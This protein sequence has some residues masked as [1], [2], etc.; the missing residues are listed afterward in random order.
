MGS[1]QIDAN[2]TLEKALRRAN[3][4]AAAT[5]VSQNISHITD[6]DELLPNG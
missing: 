2:I 5:E 1:T 4:L 3:L 6:I